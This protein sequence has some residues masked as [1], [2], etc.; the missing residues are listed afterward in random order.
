MALEIEKFTIPSFENAELLAAQHWNNF[1]KWKFN[2]DINYDSIFSGLREIVKDLESRQNTFC[3][4]HSLISNFIKDEK[5]ARL[6]RH[7][8]DFGSLQHF[9]TQQDIQLNDVLKPLVTNLGKKNEN[10][11]E[12]YVSPYLHDHLNG[13]K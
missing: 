12:V 10:E 4:I 8:R 2:S 11:L 1:K 5:S 13:E 6:Y 3:S 9:G 7:L